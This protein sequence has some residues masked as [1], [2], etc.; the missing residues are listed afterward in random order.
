MD[1]L[2]KAPHN[3]L[4]KALDFHLLNKPK[5]YLLMKKRIKTYSEK[6]FGVLQFEIMFIMDIY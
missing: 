3:V 1:V 6:K 5:R 2:L 4:L